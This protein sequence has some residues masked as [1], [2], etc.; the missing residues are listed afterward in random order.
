MSPNFSFLANDKAHC[1][2]PVC[3]I[4]SRSVQ[5]ESRPGNVYHTTVAMLITSACWNVYVFLSE[6]RDDYGSERSNTAIQQVPD[7]I[8]YVS[9][10]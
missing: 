5:N 6:R 7:R 9:C 4:D 3:P 10:A 1:D 2:S 8:L